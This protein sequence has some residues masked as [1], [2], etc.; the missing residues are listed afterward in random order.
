VIAG[1]QGRDALFTLDGRTGELSAKPVAHHPQFDVHPWLLV[2]QGRVVGLRYTID[3]EVTQ[4]LE[5]AWQQLQQQVDRLLPA[6]SNRLSLPSHGD[7]PWVLV[8]SSSDQQPYRAFV[9]NRESPKLTRLGDYRPAIDAKRMGQ[10]DLHWIRA[11]DGLPLPVW[12]TLPAN[13]PREKLPLVVWVHGGPWVRGMSWRWDPEV[14]FLASRGYAVLQ[15]EFRGSTG[16]G[17]A[18][19]RAGWKQWGQAMQTDLVDAA[20]WAIARGTADARRV[21]ILGASYGGYATL[22]GLAQ[23]PELFKAG[24]AW[25]SVTD[26]DML[27]GLRWSDA[28]AETRNL[29]LPRLLGDR[30]ADAA[31]LAAHSPLKQASRIRNPVLLAHGEWDSRV[32][33]DHPEALRAALK[34]HNPRVD[35]VLY[36]GEGHGWR[37]TDNLLDFWKRVERFLAQHLK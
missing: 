20:R 6:T 27:Y 35:W 8:E 4:W 32:P 28:T 9:F 29:G 18:H 24:V 21:G 16:Y 23:E 5:P 36:E 19:F 14:Q 25:A 31:M 7:S 15:P 17:F 13:G 26:L 3:A 30:V 1:H 22:M 11:R 33:L 12:L 10:T 37:Q 2:H 34:P